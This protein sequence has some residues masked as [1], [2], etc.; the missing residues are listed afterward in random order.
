[1]KYELTPAEKSTVKITMTFTHE[2][3]EGAI[4]EAYL[5]NR[6]KYAVN[7][8]RKGKVPRP[9]L[10]RYYGKGLFYEDALNLL[11]SEHYSKVLDA[12]KDLFVVGEPSLSLGED[13]SEENVVL[14]AQVPV[15]PDVQIGQYKGIK[16]NRYAYTVSDAEVDAEIHS[17]LVRSAVQVEITDRPAQMGDTVTIDFV[18]KL[19]GVPFPGGTAQGHALELG[20]HAFI[21]GFEEGVVGM[22]IGETRDITV[23]FPEEYHEESLRG[24]ETVFTVTLHKIS[25]KQIPEL[26]DE[27]AKKF[28]CDSADAYRARI[29]SYLEQ[30]AQRRSRDETERSILTEIAK[31]ASA[32]IPD[33]LIDRQ[34][35]NFMYN[36]ERNLTRQGI[37]LADYLNY[38]G[39]TRE[40]YKT[41]MEEAARTEVLHQL[42]IEKIL[43]VE[44][45][46][47]PEEEVK[48]IIAKQA[49]AC[50]KPLDEYEKNMPA[51]QREYIVNDVRLRKLFD[52]LMENNEMVLYVE[53]PRETSSETPA[54]EAAPTETP[55]ETPA[56]EAPAA[57]KKRTR[58]K[59]ETDENA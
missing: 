57:P 21:P 4:G 55:A 51:A 39:T 53:Q 48:E 58:K 52:F 2:E 59:K 5:Q 30:D 36:V 47:A 18:G 43:E 50:G 38:L 13:F 37:R 16:I 33:A 34:E 35:E 6:K 12:E 8:F 31:T 26:D 7:G 1:M 56:E 24:K 54:E 20:S 45:I 3:W 14:I 25:G 44:K 23:T 9:V 42:I 41:T 32:E 46:E 10:E 17:A 22:T 40:E 29:R 27:F 11:F 19:D 28:N 49:E 15:K